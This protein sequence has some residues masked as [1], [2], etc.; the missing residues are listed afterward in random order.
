MFDE[1][2]NR[3]K[4]FYEAPWNIKLPRRMPVILRIDGRSFHSYTSDCNKPFDGHLSNALDTVAITLCEEIQGACL[5]YLQSDEI[6]ILIHNYKTHESQAFF[7]NKLQKMVSVCASIA[8]AKMTKLSVEVFGHIK[9]AHFDA[10]TMVIPENDIENY[11]LWR[12]LD[13]ER[14]SV[15]MLGRSKFSHK[16]LHNKNNKEIQEMLF[17]HHGINWN[18]LEPYWKRGR[19]AIK[20]QVE[21]NGQIRNVWTIDR[22]IPRFVNEGRDYINRFFKEPNEQNNEAA[23][24]K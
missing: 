19:C 21:H 7:D 3:F 13:C 6:S 1:I 12:Q 15:Q 11:F 18:N 24:S 14:N 22:N 2:G 4:E 23:T 17:Q 9:E 16:E 5:A 20:K 8:A 10:R